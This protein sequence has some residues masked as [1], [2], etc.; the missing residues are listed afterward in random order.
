MNEGNQFAKGNP[1]N[2]T[3]FKKGQKPWNKG[4]KAS[5][6]TRVK[7]REAHLGQ[8]AWNTGLT[9]YKAGAAHWSYGKKRPDVAGPNS[10]FWRGGIT[11]PNLLA[12][13]SAEYKRWRTHVF[14]RD[15]YTCQACGK[16]GKGDLHADHELPF[17]KFPALR[18]EI[19]N[20]RTLCI[21]CHKNTPTYGSLASSFD[22]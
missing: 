16:R 3:S 10:N 6:A 19:L 7:L 18:F 1:P 5:D 9:G 21:P 17:S 8:R 12:R 4:R 13:T 22:I 15:D 14:Q 2:R 20:G 11:Q